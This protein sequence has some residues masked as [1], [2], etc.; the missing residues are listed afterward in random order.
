MSKHIIYYSP[1]PTGMYLWIDGNEFAIIPNAVSIQPAMMRDWWKVVDAK[2][3]IIMQVTA[4][5]VSKQ[6]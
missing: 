3:N 2:G 6:A 4:Q 5:E 1:R